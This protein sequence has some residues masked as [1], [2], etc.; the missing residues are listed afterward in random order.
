MDDIH[1]SWLAYKIMDFA[2]TPFRPIL[3][4]ILKSKGCSEDIIISYNEAMFNYFITCVTIQAGDTNGEYTR[5]KEEL[6]TIPLPDKVILF[7]SS[8]YVKKS[9][10]VSCGY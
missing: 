1:K 5:L 8:L 6:K 2:M 9:I 7:S 3:C 4:L 10:A